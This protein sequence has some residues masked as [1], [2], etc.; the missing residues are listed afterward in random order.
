MRERGK[1]RLIQFKMQSLLAPAASSLFITMLSWQQE[2]N[3]THFIKT[4]T[5]TLHYVAMVTGSL[6]KEHKRCLPYN[7]LVLG[8]LNGA[9]FFCSFSKKHKATKQKSC[10]KP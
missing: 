8:A 4:H 7:L 1:G 6:S 3:N 5:H 2:S 10:H 9:L